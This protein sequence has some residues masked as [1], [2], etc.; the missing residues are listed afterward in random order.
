MEAIKAGDKIRTK[1][2]GLGEVEAVQALHG[3]F[4]PG[5]YVRYRSINKK[6]GLPWQGMKFALLA[7][8]T[9]V[10]DPA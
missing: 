6:T 10:E 4:V 8:V 5:V 2:G 9:L 7:D 1:S 3:A